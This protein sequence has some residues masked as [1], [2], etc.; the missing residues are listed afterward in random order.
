[1][2]DE[3]TIQCAEQ[4]AQIAALQREQS[5]L[6][7]QIDELAR[8]VLDLDFPVY[9]GEGA[10]DVAVR[11]LKDMA[12]HEPGS[13]DTWWAYECTGKCS[14]Q[15][16]GLVLDVRT[17]DSAFPSDGAFPSISCPICHGPVRFGGSW[18]A[19]VN[20]YGSRGDRD[21]MAGVAADQALDLIR[22]LVAAM[23]AWG[24]WEDG[25]PDSSCFS[26]PALGTAYDRAKAVLGEELR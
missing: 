23:E 20:G 4:Q 25:V 21:G 3:L 13:T 15:G 11:M 17:D 16:S 2:S 12:T 26:K 8:C 14:K 6:Q 19:D 24:S 1:M 5:R 7:G 18:P 22:D 10:V 9:D